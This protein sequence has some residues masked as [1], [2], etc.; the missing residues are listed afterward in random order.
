MHEDAKYDNIS[1]SDFIA[2]N[3]EDLKFGFMQDEVSEM[4]KNKVKNNKKGFTPQNTKGSLG[5]YSLLT[6]VADTNSHTSNIV[7]MEVFKAKEIISDKNLKLKNILKD[8]QLL[9]PVS[10]VV[11]KE[12][13]ALRHFLNLRIMELLYSDTNK[14]F[15]ILSDATSA[16]VVNPN[17][18]FI[19]KYDN[20]NHL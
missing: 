14:L 7:A 6:N 9:Y 20:W 18:I 2:K 4:I 12:D 19:H 13:T 5:F 10:F 3:N 11:R 15:N 17:D 16:T 8:K 1:Y